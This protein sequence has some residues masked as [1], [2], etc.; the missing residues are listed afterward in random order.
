MT[1]PI[2]HNVSCKRKFAMYLCDQG[3]KIWFKILQETET[4]MEIMPERFFGRV[5]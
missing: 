3:Q 2:Y 5:W 4:L 1:G